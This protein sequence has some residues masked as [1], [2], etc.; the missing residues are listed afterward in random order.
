VVKKVHT[1][2]SENMEKELDQWVKTAR[3]FMSKTQIGD[4]ITEL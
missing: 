3:F 2:A 4:F 1:I